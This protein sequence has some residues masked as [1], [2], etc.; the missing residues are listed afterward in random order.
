[1]DC[2][3]TRELGVSDNDLYRAAGWEQVQDLIHRQVL[4]WV[5]HVARMPEDRLPKQPFL[6]EVLLE[7]S[8]LRLFC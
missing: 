2:Y 8:P 5:G 3:N 4:V 6:L 7:A 1:M